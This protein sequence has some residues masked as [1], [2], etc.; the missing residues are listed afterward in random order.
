MMFPQAQQK[1]P[2][3]WKKSLK[4]IGFQGLTMVEISGIE[5]LTS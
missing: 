4:A 5:P 1:V 2:Q 3:K